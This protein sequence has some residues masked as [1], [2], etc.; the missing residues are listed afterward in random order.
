MEGTTDMF[1]IMNY[2]KKKWRTGLEFGGGF[3]CVNLVQKPQ[4]P[5]MLGLIYC[6]GLKGICEAGFW[7]KL[8][9]C[10]K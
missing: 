5:K 1:E 7:K 3:G 6:K 8:R 9:V 10:L 4:I 2:G